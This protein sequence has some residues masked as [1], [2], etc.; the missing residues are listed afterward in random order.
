MKRNQMRNKPK[1]I[2]LFVLLALVLPAFALGQTD[3]N[4]VQDRAQIKDQARQRLDEAKA[5]GRE[6]R[7]QALKHLA[8]AQVDRT[9]K[10]IRRLEGL[11]SKIESAMNA[12]QE[13]GVDTSALAAS[14]DK[15][16]S[17]KSEALAMLADLKTKYS[18]IDPALPEPRRQVQAFLT[19]MNQ[20]KKKLIELHRSLVDIVK[21]IRSLD[22]P[23][24]STT[25]SEE[26]Q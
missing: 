4:R 24:Q 11:I 10:A 2:S 9:E 16:K 3:T 15:A 8:E 26:S 17:L 23:A 21:Q 1:I 5:Q 6:A 25:N 19:G 14:L 22:K 13:R 20:L 12:L 7:I 18:S